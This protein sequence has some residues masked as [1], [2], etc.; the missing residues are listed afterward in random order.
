MQS[1]GGQKDGSRGIL[2]RDCREDEG[3]TVHPTVATASLVLRLVCG[4]AL[5]CRRTWIFLLF[6]VVVLLPVMFKIAGVR[7]ATGLPCTHNKKPA[8]THTHTHISLYSRPYLAH[9]TAI[10]VTHKIRRTVIATLLDSWVPNTCP[11]KML[12]PQKKTASP[13]LFTYSMERSPS[14]EA[15]W[16]C[17]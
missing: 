3:G 13:Y 9:E 16:F 7:I 11:V 10:V 15:N 17:S 8:R 6:L 1:S 14:W 4:Q 2:N 5:S 12:C